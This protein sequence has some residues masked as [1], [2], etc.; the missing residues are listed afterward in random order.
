MSSSPPTARRSSPKVG[1]IVQLCQMTKTFAI[2]KK[3]KMAV[4]HLAMIQLFFVPRDFMAFHSL[5]SNK[6]LLKS[7]NKDLLTTTITTLGFV[8]NFRN[9]RSPCL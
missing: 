7:S 3:K 5:A 9:E 2:K 8:Q 4:L 1:H 6:D